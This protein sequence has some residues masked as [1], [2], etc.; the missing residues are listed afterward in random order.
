MVTAATLCYTDP[1]SGSSIYERDRSPYWWIAYWSPTKLKRV[2][3]SSGVRLDDPQGKRKALGILREKELEASALQPASKSEAWNC[4]VLEFLR[5]RYGKSPETLI[6]YENAW[7]WISLYLTDQKLIVPRQ[8]TY[9]N[10]V[11]Y[12]KWRETFKKRGN[13]TVCRNTALTDV[14]VW[15]IIMR[16]AV[17]RGFAPLNPCE[18]L[19][20]KKERPAEKPEI[21]D[22]EIRK[23]REGLKNRPDWMLISFE[24]ALHQGCRLSETQLPMAAI[25]LE[26]ETVQFDAKGGKVFTTKLHPNLKP[27][28]SKLKAQRRRFACQLPKMAAKEWHFFFKEI[29]LPHLCFHCTRVTAITRMA[30]M[31]V[32]I[33]KAMRFVGHANETIHKVYQRLQSSDLESCVDALK[34]DLPAK[35]S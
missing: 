29:G 14:K 2:C 19:G 3:E 33:Q 11:N 32:P 16:D 23:I 28:L 25:D 18:R 6:R 1:M 15:R 7:D 22:E 26:R 24:I 31:G 30:R 13:R 21:T 5:D 35:T 17:R 10:V 20:I 27:M 8:V 12:V 34:F 4:W 9:Q